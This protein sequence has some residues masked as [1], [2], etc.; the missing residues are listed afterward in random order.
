MRQAYEGSLTMTS[1]RVWLA[2]A[3]LSYQFDNLTYIRGIWQWDSDTRRREISVLLAHV[4]NYATQ[5]HVG[6]E[7]RSTDGPE[8][9]AGASRGPGF[10]ARVSYLLRR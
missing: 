3:R 4:L 7:S 10:F 5:I 2:R 8:S 1:T 6:F 9:E